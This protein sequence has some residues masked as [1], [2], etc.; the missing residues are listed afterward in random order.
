MPSSIGF[1]ELSSL[2][3]IDSGMHAPGTTRLMNCAF[4]ADLSRKTPAKTGIF[5]GS[6]ISLQ[7]RSSTLGS[8]TI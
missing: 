2:E 1:D 4:L 5:I 7:N 8:I 6:V 3:I